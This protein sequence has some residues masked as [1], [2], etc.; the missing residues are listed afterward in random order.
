MLRDKKEKHKSTWAK[1]GYRMS[2][3]MSVST[4]S[5]ALNGNLQPCMSK[6]PDHQILVITGKTRLT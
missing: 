1:N 6:Y 5:I 4:R 3:R 2:C